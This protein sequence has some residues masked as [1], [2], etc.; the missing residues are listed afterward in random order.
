[1]KSTL[2]SETKKIGVVP[3]KSYFLLT[4]VIHFK[5]FSYST[6]VQD[7]IVTY[8][9]FPFFQVPFNSTDSAGIVYGWIGRVSS[10]A[11]S[12]LMEDIISDMFGD[13]FS[14]QVWNLDKH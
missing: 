14:V 4:C 13:E 2:C 1:M 10:P 3:Q 8:L 5:F 12:R 6:S 11:Q 9:T 7:F